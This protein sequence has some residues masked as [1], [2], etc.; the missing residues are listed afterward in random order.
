[1]AQAFNAYLDADKSD[2]FLLKLSSYWKETLV[3]TI[4]PETIRRAARKVYPDAQ[5]A[6]WNRQVIVPTVAAINYAASLGW[7]NPI[8][9]KRFPVNTKKKTPA[10]LA[11]INAHSA[12]ALA[13]GLPHLA[14]LSLFLYA[15]GA[16]ISEAC[17]LTWADVDLSQAVATIRMGKPTPWERTAHL[18][19]QV[20][21]A[22][23]SIGGNRNPTELVFGYEGRDSVTKVWNNVAG[24][25]EIAPLTPHCCRHGFA[26]S[27][28]HKGFDPKTVAER[29]GWKDAAT[30]LR[31]YAHALK[32]RTVTDALF[33]TE[34]TQAESLSQVTI[35]KGR[36]NFG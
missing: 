4:T 14:A 36:S 28:L 32:D 35:G 24:R 25:A 10:D 26:T 1:M 2:R 19:P 30:V 33:G 3:E 8:K 27:M 15:T 16:R 29:G 21:A 23:G 13:D 9:V 11:W 18:P 12:Q 34:V 7:C 20:I 6:T 22:M 31:T 17:R 5:P